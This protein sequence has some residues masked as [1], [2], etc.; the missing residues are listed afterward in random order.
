MNDIRA[1]AVAE[2]DAGPRR[3]TS[4]PARVEGDMTGMTA[5]MGT[6]AKGGVHDGLDKNGN[7]GKETGGGY[8]FAVP[9]YSSSQ[10]AGISQHLATIQ[11]RLR[12]VETENAVSR[13]RVKDLEAELERAKAEVE[14]A[15]RGNGE[16][17]REVIGE[18][19]GECQEFSVR[20]LLR[21]AL[22]D[23]IT[24]LRSHLARLTAEVEQNKTLIDELR[25]VQQRPAPR[26]PP[27]ETPSVADELI[28]LRKEVER[29]GNEVHR[30]GGIVEEGLDTRRRARGE[31][32]IRMEQDEAARLVSDLQEE[33]E[34]RR[35][36]QEME[37]RSRFQAQAARRAPPPTPGPSKLR[38]GLHAAAVDS[39]TL[40]PPTAAPPTRVTRQRT[41]SQNPTPPT[42]DEEHVPPTPTNMSTRRRSTGLATERTVR[43]DGPGS[44]FPSIRAE[45]EEDFFEAA[46]R[47][48]GRQGASASTRAAG[49]PN[50]S[51][52]DGTRKVSSSSGSS[53][54]RR[55][56]SAD[57]L[58]PQ[59]VL[60]RVIR[61]LEADFKHYKT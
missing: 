24:S 16:R 50:R 25:R 11:A 47:A 48:Q 36:Q 59:T 6:P 21:P 29:L 9:S 46:K 27:R 12:A 5:L 39:A 40:M 41:R 57:D 32:T 45:D 31:R 18:K 17:L 13:R 8:P 37:R 23:L 54:R 4:A 28:A 58:P 3:P 33:D 49:Q 53:D 19:T 2:K 20:H 60:T 15:R 51:A 42:S 56:G 52:G 1:E 7:V 43:Q 55:S 14:T 10:A 26:S 34:M 44:P 38:P 61:E 22:E 30:L 35:I